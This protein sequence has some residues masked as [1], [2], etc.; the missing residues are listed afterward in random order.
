MLIRR[1]PGASQPDLPC[2][3]EPNLV[4]L[5]CR[6][7]QRP[8]D[9]AEA[10]LSTWHGRPGRSTR[11]RRSRFRSLPGALTKAKL[12]RNSKDQNLILWFCASCAFCGK[13]SSPRPGSSAIALRPGSQRLNRKPSP[14]LALPG[15]SPRDQRDNRQERGG[16]P[17]GHHCKIG[18]DRIVGRRYLIVPCGK[19]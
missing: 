8:S 17:E 7:I 6:N 13:S 4:A 15:L 12:V 19:S 18:D 3:L 2:P 11:R 14:S 9:P 16:T 1:A 5:H 10:A